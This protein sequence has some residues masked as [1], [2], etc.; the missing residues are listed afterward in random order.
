MSK[1][2]RQTIQRRKTNLA[3]PSSIESPLELQEQL[4]ALGR[5]VA[6]LVPGTSPDKFVE[7]MNRILQEYLSDKSGSKKSS[8]SNQ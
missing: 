2:E 5:L 8:E 6:R 4:D 1:A 3:S 7:T